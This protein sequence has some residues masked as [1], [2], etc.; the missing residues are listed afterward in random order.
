MLP[1]V[2]ARNYTGIELRGYL[3]DV[4]ILPKLKGASDDA[5]DVIGIVAEDGATIC[6]VDFSGANPPLNGKCASI[7]KSVIG[8]GEDIGTSIKGDR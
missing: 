5:D 4:V 2:E 1:L 3:V 8:D 7:N 6:A